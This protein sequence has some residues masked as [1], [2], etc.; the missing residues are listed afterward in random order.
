MSP[1]LRRFSLVAALGVIAALGTGC[2][3]TSAVRV[4]PWERGNL[5]DA[6]MNPDRDPLASALSDHVNFAR[7]A[8]NGGKGV[9]GSGCGCN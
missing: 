1:C 2:T 9:G 7:E 8:A 6:T 4:R 3:T 5:A